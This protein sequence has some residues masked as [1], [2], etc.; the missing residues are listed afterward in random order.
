[1]ISLKLISRDSVEVEQ[2]VHMEQEVEVVG[3]VSYST[4][5]VQSI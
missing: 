1:M 5:L 3:E 2:L 4:S